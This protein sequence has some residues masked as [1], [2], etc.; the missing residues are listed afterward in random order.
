M[1]FV[2]LLAEPFH[3]GYR[4]L[5]DRLGLEFCEPDDWRQAREMLERGE[6]RAGAICGL[7]Y[8]LLR[9]QGIDLHPVAAPL[10]KHQRYWGPEYW[11]DVVVSADSPISSFEELEGQ[12]WLFNEPQSFSGYRS[13]LAALQQ[14]QLGPNF[15]AAEIET[16][17]HRQSLDQLLAGKGDFA[18]LDSTFLDGLPQAEQAQVRVVESLG[19][20]PVPLMVAYPEVVSGL[21]EKLA[22]PD[23][24]PE[25]FGGFMAASD[26]RY[27]A[28]RQAWNLSLDYLQSGEQYFLEQEEWPG[29][30]F[31]SQQQRT[32][33]QEILRRVGRELPR[34]LSA[35]GGEQLPNGTVFH[36]IYR[37]D[38]EHHNYLIEPRGLSGR[39]L[40]LVGFLSRMKPG[41]D[42]PA[43]FE[44]D[45]RLIEQFHKYEGFLSYSPT[46]YKPGRWANLA[47]FRDVAARDRWA[48]NST[49]LKAIRELGA[50][51]YDNVRLHLGVW[52]SL[53]QE[54][55][56][57]TTRYLHYT[58][59]G[60]WRGVYCGRPGD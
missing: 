37:A 7:L 42:L 36:R 16:G 1:K 22:T 29:R 12:R 26:R 13:F 49:H 10:L 45:A 4:E 31:T 23:V 55:Q 25:P 39:N 56:W 60:L 19:P 9:A 44:A 2:S 58:E 20:Y 57:F 32:Q 34:Y 33:D 21:V 52:P 40:A 48:A 47:V 5:C 24:Y 43:L 11:A 38:L 46:E 17:G 41:G 8:T 15:V 3:S 59:D 14:R 18:V 30:P 28:L 50:D 35:K 6:A 51:S 53:E 54:Q 27:N